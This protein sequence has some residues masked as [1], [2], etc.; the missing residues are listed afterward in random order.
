MSRR[1]MHT[2]GPAA[3]VVTP[4]FPSS[5]SNLVFRCRADQGIVQTSNAVATWADISGNGNHF[6]QSTALN[7]PTLVSSGINSQP[8]VRFDGANT[9]LV[10]PARI[11]TSIHTFVALVKT[12]STRAA[13]TYAG[14][15]ANTILGDQSGSVNTGF[16]ITNSNAILH[17]YTGAWQSQT[18]PTNV[19]DGTAHLIIG[20]YDATSG[21]AQVIVDGGTASSSTIPTGVTTTSISTIGAGYKDDLLTDA[22]DW[23]NGD[24]GEVLGY[25]RALTN[26]EI[27]SLHTYFQQFWGVA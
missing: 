1:G 19:S 10:L 14:N 3:T 20:T 5:I 9:F 25:S 17:V 27:A 22:Q 24:I 13:S 6:A 21:L 7:K 12:S 23:F 11:A 4:T 26:T 18:N 8:I 2:G 16:G 15:G